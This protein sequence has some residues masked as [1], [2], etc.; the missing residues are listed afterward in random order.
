VKLGDAPDIWLLV[1]ERQNPASVSSPGH[2]STQPASRPPRQ[3]DIDAAHA[4]DALDAGRLAKIADAAQRF[5]QFSI[6]L[7][8]LSFGG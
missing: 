3:L 6:S 7:A 2:R 8:Q 5:G 4:S 1:D